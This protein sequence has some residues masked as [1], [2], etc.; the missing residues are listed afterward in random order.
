MEESGRFGEIRLW[1]QDG[2]CDLS[3]GID[4]LLSCHLCPRSRTEESTTLLLFHYSSHFIHNIYSD[5]ANMYVFF[6]IENLGSI[7]T[8]SASYFLFHDMVL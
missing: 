6:V 2:D 1:S 7:S 5:T 8:I 4:N 3:G